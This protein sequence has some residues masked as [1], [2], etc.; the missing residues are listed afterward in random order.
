MII[1]KQGEQKL[2]SADYVS[3]LIFVKDKKRKKQIY[4]MFDKDD[5]VPYNRPQASRVGPFYTNLSCS[6]M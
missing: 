4:K 2:V 6:M 5:N 1:S 3:I